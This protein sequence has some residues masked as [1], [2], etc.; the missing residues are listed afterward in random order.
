[1]SVVVSQRPFDATHPGLQIGLE[2]AQSTKTIVNY[3]RSGV[4]RCLGACAPCP[5]HPGCFSRDGEAAGHA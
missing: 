3:R 4:W 5:E 2:G 1:M